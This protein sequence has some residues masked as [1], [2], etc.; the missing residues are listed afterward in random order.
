MK[1]NLLLLS[2][3]FVVFSCSSDSTSNGNSG[4]AATYNGTLFQSIPTE[5]S[6]INFVNQITEDLEYN[7]FVNDAILQGAGVGILD[8]NNDGLKDIFLCGNMVD[9]KLFINKGDFKFE[10]ITKKAG[11]QSDKSWSTGV[12]IVCLLYT[13]PS[14]RD[15][16]KSRMPSSA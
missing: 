2:F 16:Q 4:T 13:S 10:D 8:V 6:G 3:V 7:T 9:D 15:R 11:L 12:S 5:E 1:I 14:P